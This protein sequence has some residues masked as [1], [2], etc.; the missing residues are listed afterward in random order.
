[1]NSHLDFVSV[2]IRRYSRL[3]RL[4]VKCSIH[5]HSLHR[6]FACPLVPYTCKLMHGCIITTVLLQCNTHNYD[7]VLF[8]TGSL[9]NQNHLSWDYLEEIQKW[10]KCFLFQK[11]NLINNREEKSLRHVAMVA[12]FLDDNKP[13][14]H[15]KSGFALFQS[16]LI[17]FNFI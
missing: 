7:S 9:Q 15:L 3:R 17:L 8:T 10:T 13:K 11:V 2:T 4:I 5:V 14:C 12:K 16:S 1:M 6:V